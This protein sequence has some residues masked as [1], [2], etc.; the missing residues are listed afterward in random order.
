MTY[1]EPE[2][3]ITY[4]LHRVTNDTACGCSHF[5]AHD[6]DGCTATW[7]QYA[8]TIHAYAARCGCRK[9]HTQSVHERLVTITMTRSVTA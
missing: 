4:N 1:T 8:G 5:D 9:H 7:I 3:P 2:A 6:A